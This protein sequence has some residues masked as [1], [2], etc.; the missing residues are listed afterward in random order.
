[1]KKA[2]TSA[3]FVSQSSLSP[4]S[5]VTRKKGA[6]GGVRLVQINAMDKSSKKPLENTPLVTPLFRHVSKIPSL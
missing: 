3:C 2:I 6:A 5:S 1:M 4:L